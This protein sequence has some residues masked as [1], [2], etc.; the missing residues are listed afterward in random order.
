[1]FLI[2]YDL[3]G[4]VYSDNDLEMLNSGRTYSDNDLEMLSPQDENAG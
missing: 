4:R 3:G 2:V 1:M